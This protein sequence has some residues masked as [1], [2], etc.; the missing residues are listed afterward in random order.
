M[1]SWFTFSHFKWLLVEVL[2]KLGLVVLYKEGTL[3]SHV[4]AE[5]IYGIL[6]K[7]D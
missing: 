4:W 7:F 6:D 3:V 1:Y 5:W 2:A